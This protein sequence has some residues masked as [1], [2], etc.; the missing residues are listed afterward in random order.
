MKMEEKYA[1]LVRNTKGKALFSTPRI[2]WER[3]LILKINF[4]G[5]QSETAL[6]SGG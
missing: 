2:G 6:D 4:T 3:R 5:I 1:I